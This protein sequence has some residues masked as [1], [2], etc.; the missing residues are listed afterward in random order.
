MLNNLAGVVWL[1]LPTMLSVTWFPPPERTLATSVGLM[2]NWLGISGSFFFGQAVVS[3]PHRNATSRADFD[4]A[5]PMI[6]RYHNVFL[7]LG[8]QQPE[9]SEVWDRSDLGVG[10]EVPKLREEILR[11]MWITA[12]PIVTVSATAI[13]F[14][15]QRPPLP[16]SRSSVG[17]RMEF[18]TGFKS[19]V[20]KRDS[21]L[22]AA[23]ASVPYGL[24][25][26]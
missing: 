13:L 3:E 22:L 16:P 21:W 25:G 2:A 20:R 9:C 11:L 23:I 24:F 10:D 8:G 26:E 6:G 12:I 5:P 15:P 17:A 14:F 18:W 19:L 7:Y 1:T 4:L